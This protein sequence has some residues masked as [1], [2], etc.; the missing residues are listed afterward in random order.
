MMKRMI[1]ST[2]TLGLLIIP[3]T[4]A[5]ADTPEPGNTVSVQ[6][7]LWMKASAQGDMSEIAMG[8]LAQVKSSYQSVKSYGALLASDHLKALAERQMIAEKTGIT[9]PTSPNPEQMATYNL[10]LTSHSTHWSLDFV[11]HE[12][13]DHK[14]SIAMTNEEIANGT[15]IDIRM[16]AEKDLP[17]LMKHLE[18][19]EELEG[20]LSK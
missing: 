5:W 9:L 14:K 16:K 13:L 7:K 2:F 11:R 1:A 18:V 8:E 6:D 15:N 4:H 10:F 12:I 3:A 19:A 17:V 20:E